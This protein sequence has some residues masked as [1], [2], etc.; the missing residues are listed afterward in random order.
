MKKIFTLFL[1]FI[2]TIFIYGTEFSVFEKETLDTA[3]NFCIHAKENE[4]IK[5]AVNSI[6]EYKN[7]FNDDKNSLSEEAVLTINNFLLTEAISINMD[8]YSE[9]KKDFK[10]DEYKSVILE[11][12]EKNL[13]W[14]KTHTIK[15]S[16]PYYTL[17]RINVTTDAMAFLPKSQLMK[18]MKQMKQDYI[19][20]MT[21]FPDFSMGLY[22]VGMM[23]YM[24]P[25]IAGGN[26]KQGRELLE[27]AVELASNEYEVFNSNLMFSQILLEEK[28]ENEAAKSFKKVE[29][30][31]PNAK[32]VKLIKDVNAAGYSVFD[33]MTNK[34]KIDKK[35][36]KD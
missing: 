6:F 13:E 22:T 8:E 17:S 24:M 20:L 4:N 15:D 19:D 3:L 28:N 29:E 21:E 7:K 31:I 10:V 36:K 9:N 1:I 2:S 25:A 34:D 11:Q 16:N 35:I 12:Y 27:K 18:M 30:I 32:Y 33:Y 14:L 23:L 5:S 26:K